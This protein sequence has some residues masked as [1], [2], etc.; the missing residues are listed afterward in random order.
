MGCE[1][2]CGVKLLWHK[3]W[4]DMI[5]YDMIW[6]DIVSASYLYP[7][8]LAS[9]IDQMRALKRWDRVLLIREKSTQSLN[10]GIGQFLHKYARADAA[11]LVI[12]RTLNLL[13]PLFVVSL[14]GNI[15]KPSHLYPLT[16]PQKGPWKATPTSNHNPNP[17]PN[18]FTNPI[19]PPPSHLPPY[20]ASEG[21]LK[22]YSDRC[23]QIWQRQKEA[24]SYRA[25]VMWPT[26]GIGVEA[27]SATAVT[28]SGPG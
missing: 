17:N 23:Y 19:P 11:R 3:S 24:L 1:G 9:V 27:A 2:G 5:W 12:Y 16:V 26:G 15:F 22:S 7:L 14:I 21:T 18:P 25:N 13:W 28:D 6:Y 10:A 20:S 4:F 8:F